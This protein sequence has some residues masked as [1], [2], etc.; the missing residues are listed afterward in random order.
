MER[1]A[2]HPSLQSASKESFKSHSFLATLNIRIGAVL[3]LQTVLVDFDDLEQFNICT[4]RTN[5]WTIRGLHSLVG[6]SVAFAE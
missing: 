2:V 1:P 6:K 4:I 3:A 5:T